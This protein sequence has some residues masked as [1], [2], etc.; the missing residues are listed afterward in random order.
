[1][2]RLTAFVPKRGVKYDKSL[3][4]YVILEFE[5]L[6]AQIAP[7]LATFDAQSF[8]LP[9]GPISN[10]FLT[11]TTRLFYI[12]SFCKPIVNQPIGRI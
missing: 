12:N 6:K 9:N 3:F 10:H 8:Y 11:K 5:V 7:V 1:M 4:Q 2:H